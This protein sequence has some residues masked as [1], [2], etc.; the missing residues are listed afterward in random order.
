MD[1]TDFFHLSLSLSEIFDRISKR[2]EERNFDGGGGE[3]TYKCKYKS[4][5]NYV[6]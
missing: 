6:Y 2:I 5:E 4:I 1:G 3:H